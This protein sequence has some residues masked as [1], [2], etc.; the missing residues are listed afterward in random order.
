MNIIEKNYNGITLID[1]SSKLLEDRIIYLQD[2]LNEKTASEFAKAMMFLI[3]KD[4]TSSIKIF[5]NSR[6]G[7]VNSGLMIY[8]IIQ[9]CEMPVYL[10]CLGQAYSMAAVIL[11]GGQKGRRL[12]L[13]QSKVMI[14]EPLID[15]T[16]GPASSIK[17]VA[18]SI[19]ETREII[20][21]ILSKHTGKSIEEINRITANDY[22]MTAHKSVEFGI[23]DR[24]I[25]FTEMM[26]VE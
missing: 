23:C 5:I 6:G 8:D 20:N 10:C 24:V 14:H 25:N 3:K 17:S 18:D 22:Y 7:E 21:G 15:A 11:A 1:L 13:P 4:A 12:I 16:G 19:M 9:S 2:E 26:E